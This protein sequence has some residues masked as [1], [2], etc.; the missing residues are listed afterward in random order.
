M[1]F[2]PEPD[3]PPFIKICGLT[4]P[5]NA[6]D[7]AKAGADAIGLVFFEKSPRNVSVSRAAKITAM[8]PDKVLPW[9]VFVN[10]SFEFIM[11]VKKGCGLKAVQLHG[12]ESPELVK[13]IAKQ[14][15]MVVKAL[16]AAKAPF[17]ADTALY[18]EASAF[19]VEYGKGVLP[20]G[21]A[22]TWDYSV[23]AGLHTQ[24]PVLLAGG[25]CPDNVKEAVR[26]SR[27]WGLDISSGVE[28]S[29]GVKDLEKVRAFIRTAKGR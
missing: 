25:L 2:M 29:P 18:P 11:A 13:Q 23:S 9:G 26:L 16:F 5:A 22:E 19:L 3:R 28:K 7:C 6:K 12:K 14:G 4:D 17:L 1:S 24:K 21:N 20:G 8:L 10:E 15:L 27:P